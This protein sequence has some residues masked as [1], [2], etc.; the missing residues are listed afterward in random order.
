M[1]L[2]VANKPIIILSFANSETDHLRLLK[3][4]SRIINNRLASLHDKGFIEVYD[5][6]SLTNPELA[7]IINR[8]HE[9]LRIFHYAGHASGN[10]LFLEEG[11][12]LADGLAKLFELISE[13]L[14][15]LF[16]NG[17]STLGQ[18]KRLLELGIKSVIATAVPIADSTAVEF[19]DKFYE[20]L[21]SH[22]SIKDAFEFASAAISVSENGVE[23]PAIIEYRSIKLSAADNPDVFPWGLYVNE[24]H[25]EV[26][27]WKL[28]STIWEARTA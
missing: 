10:K 25:K 21:A 2:A 27:E 15:C 4:E 12:A 20:A 1:E 11:D 22:K 28:P 7:S 14:V 19:S 23:T 26:L 17:C 9:R 8:F 16:L 6:E 18:V 3:R 5:E 24:D 13:N